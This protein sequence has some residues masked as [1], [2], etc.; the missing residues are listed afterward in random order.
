MESIFNGLIEFKKKE[1]LKEFIHTIDE[2]NALKILEMAL[3]FANK[4]AIYTIEENHIIYICL[5]KLKEYETNGLRT[6]N[7]SGNTSS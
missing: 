4:N 1:E 7:N 6:D 2:K 3:E 5:S